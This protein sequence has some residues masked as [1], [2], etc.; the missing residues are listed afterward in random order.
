MPAYLPS[1]KCN[2]MGLIFSLFDIASSI[3]VPLGIPQHVKCTHHGL[4]FV[5]LCVP[6]LFADS[7]RCQFTI[8]LEC[9]GIQDVQSY[10]LIVNHQEEN[11]ELC[12]CLEIRCGGGSGVDPDF[13]KERFYS[14]T[15]QL[16]LQSKCLAAI[17]HSK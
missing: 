10:L 8:Y 9:I 14:G 3:D 1:D 7:P 2:S 4:T 5:L 15:W 6:F 13:Q 12:L 16:Q 11:Q 17:F